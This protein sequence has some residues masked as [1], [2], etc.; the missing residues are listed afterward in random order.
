MDLNYSVI[1]VGI[2]F[3]ALII[4]YAYIKFITCIISLPKSKIALPVATEINTVYPACVVME[5]QQQ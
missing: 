4:A 3:F 2:I 5:T 1:V